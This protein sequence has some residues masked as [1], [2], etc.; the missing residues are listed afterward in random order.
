MS[1][2]EPTCPPRPRPGPRCCTSPPHSPSSHSDLTFVHSNLRVNLLQKLHPGTIVGSHLHL[3]TWRIV[4]GRCWHSCIGTQIWF[5]LKTSTLFEPLLVRIPILIILWI[6]SLC[7]M[8]IHWN[9]RWEI[10]IWF[11]FKTACTNIHKALSVQ[12]SIHLFIGWWNKSFI[13]ST[14]FA[15]YSIKSTLYYKRSLTSEIITMVK[16]YNT[17]QHY[18]LLGCFSSPEGKGLLQ[19]FLQSNVSAISVCYNNCT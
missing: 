6:L 5:T 9:M 18:I 7:A 1:A 10:Q 8:C 13:T 19:S 3:I 12:P 4:M 14:A 11:Y 17:S 15:N 2:A 16:C